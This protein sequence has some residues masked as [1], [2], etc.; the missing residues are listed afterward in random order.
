[1]NHITIASTHS[2]CGTYRIAEV[3]NDIVVS[4]KTGAAQIALNVVPIYLVYPG[5]VTVT[6]GTR[7]QS[8]EKKIWLTPR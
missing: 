8:A 3:G 2:T 6:G 5:R 4:Y 1:M 7:E